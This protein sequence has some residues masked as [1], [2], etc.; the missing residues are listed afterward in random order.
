M[1]AQPCDSK[2]R[3]HLG[4]KPSTTETCCE[5]G[6]QEA[7]TNDHSRT[8]VVDQDPPAL[9][10][11]FTLGAECTRL[12]SSWSSHHVPPNGP[13]PPV[14]LS[15]THFRTPSPSIS[16]H[17]R[18][19]SPSLPP[20]TRT[21]ELPLLIDETVI[22]CLYTNCASLYN[23]T[24][25]LI[26]L[27]SLTSPDLI[28]ITETWLT[29]D[30]D[31][32]EVSIP[33]YVLFR[34][35][36]CRGRMGGVCIFSASTLCLTS[37][38][39]PNPNFSHIDALWLSLKLRNRD[40]LLIGVIYRPPSSPP[41]DNVL[42]S[43]F[44]LKLRSLPFSHFLVTGDFNAPTINW[45]HLKAP[46]SG[47]DPMLL[48]TISSLEWH[49][50]ILHPTRFR[51]GQLPSVLDLVFTNEKPMIDEVVS[52]SPLGRS[53]HVVLSWDMVCYWQ[54]AV[55]PKCPTFAFH[56]GDYTSMIRYLKATD[57]SVLTTL[58]PEE[59]EREITSKI[60]E[61][62]NLFIPLHTHTI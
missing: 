51:G 18:T 17:P 32:S 61:A 48:A 38:S 28:F 21:S 10:V 30:I 44:L 56:R 57:W 46:S 39:V 29:P 59:Q 22:K 25:E 52:L 58:E 16:P 27:V 1:S 20:S 8:T 45:H 24:S 62:C 43:N 19:H 41:E 11:P 60:T 26:D 54:T 37:F 34:S 6:S 42:L 31:D 12:A 55:F 23:K 40:R 5:Y 14:P 36:S 7:P 47:F 15:A 50:H 49:Q 33:G 3:P 2:K 4:P 53:D 13:S 35:D 9:S